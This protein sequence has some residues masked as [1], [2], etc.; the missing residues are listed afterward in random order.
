MLTID[1]L[2]MTQAL[3]WLHFCVCILWCLVG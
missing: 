3:F 2:R 1:S